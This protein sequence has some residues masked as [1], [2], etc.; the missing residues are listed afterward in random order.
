M[1]LFLT[2][3]LIACGA[4]PNPKRPDEDGLWKFPP[5]NGAQETPKKDA[6]QPATPPA[7]ASQSAPQSANDS[8]SAATSSS[9]SPA[10]S[11]STTN[12]DTGA[13]A[14]AALAASLAAKPEHA[15]INAQDADDPIVATVAGKTIGVRELLAQ[16]VH[17]SGTDA[18]DQLDHL[19]LTRLVQEE[20]RR[21]SVRIEPDKA[22]QAYADAVSKIEKKIADKRPGITLDQY[23]DQILGLDPL[24][25]RARLRA[26][27]LNQM[28]AE[29][30]TRAFTLESER[31]DIRVI[32][33][34][35]EDKVK[36]VQTAL[37][38]GEAFTDVARRLSTD[39]SSKDGGRVPPVI[40]SETVMGK[41]AFQT[42][43]GEVG[44]PQ[45]SQ[46]ACLFVR[47]EGRPEPLTG[48]WPEIAGTVE[49]SLAERTIE[50]L[51][52]SQW[53]FTMLR[54]YPVDLSPFLKLAGQPVK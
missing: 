2:L 26:D 32:V 19:V 44:G 51:E 8:K 21:L 53:K 9:T 13:D 27:A 3:A 45:Y 11:P 15:P 16:W 46:G 50:E 33:V 23:V 52:F 35:G 28:L 47:V 10:P 37:A 43:V 5:A 40:R 7:P 38:A 22:E 17:Q 41:L 39:P 18:L 54:R 14:A 1:H 25:Y 49:K 36:E 34:K 24:V 48:S 20:A 12:S 6:A 29:R 42:N 4:T 30:V 31:A